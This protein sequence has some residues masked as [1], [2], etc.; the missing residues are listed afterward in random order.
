M[1][2]NHLS[3]YLSMSHVEQA[4]YASASISNGIRMPCAVAEHLSLTLTLALTLTLVH[5]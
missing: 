2:P 3:I 4:I 1:K 5:P